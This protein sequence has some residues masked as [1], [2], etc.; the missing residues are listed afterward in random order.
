MPEHQDLSDLE[1]R[2][3]RGLK[4]LLDRVVRTRWLA[5]AVALLAAA[6][7]AADRKMPMYRPELQLQ[8]EVVEACRRSLRDGAARR[9]TVKTERD[10]VAWRASVRASFRE[11]F[12]DA[13]FER[14]RDLKARVVS[15]QE[16]DDYRVE[17]VLFESLPGWEVNGSVYLPK[18][19]GEYP[20]VVCPTGHSSKQ[21]ESYQQSAQV[22][23]RN[24]YIAISFDPPGCA[25]EIQ[26][27]NDHFTNGLIGYLTGFWSQTHFVA[28]AIACLDYLDSREDVDHDLGLSITGVSG[29]GITSFS[30]A[31]VDDRVKFVG[32]V[33]CLAE[34][35]SLHLT[36]LYTSCP[37][38]FGP[39]YI[40]GGLDYVDYIAALAPT[41][42]LIAGGK[43]DEVFDYRSTQRIYRD[44]E[45][46]YR[47]AGAPDSCGLFIDENSGHAYTVAMANEMVRWMNRV[48]KGVDDAP[49]S[50]DDADVLMIDGSLLL[51]HPSNDVNMFT[52]NRDEGRRL[53][54]ERPG[55]TGEALRESVE[56][57]LGTS[58]DAKLVR[59]EARTEPKTSWHALVE[60]IDIQPADGTHLPSL[61]FTHVEDKSPRPGMLWIDDQG[62]WA[63]FRH[64]AFLC[65]ALRMYEPDCLPN[66]P[67]ILSMDV[68][69]LGSLAPE[70]TA[71]DLAGWND[72]ERILTHLSVANSRPIMGLRV[73]DALRGLDYLRS[74]PEVDLDRLIIGGRGV[75]AIV[76]LHAAVLDGNIDRVICLEGLSHYGALTEEFPFSWQESI[77]I[78]GILR[79]YDLPDL[80]G[81]CRGVHVI[82]PADAQGSP[83]GQDV[84]DALYGGSQVVV[85]CGVD[86]GAETVAAVMASW[87]ELGTA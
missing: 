3:T 16:F 35:E 23:A 4:P 44:V 38:Q 69:G 7:V 63:A 45:R 56:A 25:G 51:C 43:T 39:G 49:L 37:E 15:S 67:R 64:G 57:A 66:Q 87:S 62:K 32:P 8:H 75:G 74:R 81:A 11:A 84:G 42:C 54:D 19:P 22:F 77:M 40:A 28:D 29:G 60:E 52:I 55:L 80:A 12:P 48:I 31:L 68:S 70:P 26:H 21:N 1:I 53:A 71:Y 72:I 79:R 9:K 41:P 50:L 65:N 27:L 24:G 61:M 58:R 78:P 33:C 36:G 20:G 86:G 85:R 34:H 47:V 46:I 5:H 30:T 6:A 18:E 82:N 76:A 17:N 59:A 2:P 73:R 14:G 83:V 13:L 10:W